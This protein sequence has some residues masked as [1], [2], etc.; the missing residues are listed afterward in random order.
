MICWKRANE[1]FSEGDQNE[2]EPT[3]PS[4]NKTKYSRYNANQ[5]TITVICRIWYFYIIISLA[6]RKHCIYSIYNFSNLNPSLA[7]Y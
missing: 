2:S 3:W 6:I 1:L 4:E 7:Y 5:S